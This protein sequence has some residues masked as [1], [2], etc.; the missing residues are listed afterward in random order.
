[1]TRENCVV[2]HTYN[3]WSVKLLFY[4]QDNE[5]PPFYLSCIHLSPKFSKMRLEELETIQAD[6]R[7]LISQ[8]QLWAGDF[9]ALTKNDYT[10]QEWN[11]IDRQRLE[12]GRQPLC[13]KV[14]Q[15]NDQIHVDNFQSY[16]R[17]KRKEFFHE[18]HMPVKVKERKE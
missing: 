16:L 15:V 18:W 5:C 1:M 12:N 2:I 13:N 3:V 11:E 10:E 14:T 4:V 7:P 6:L 9:N 8:P 17:S